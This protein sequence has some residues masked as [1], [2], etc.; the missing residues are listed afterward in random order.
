MADA[1]IPL[2]V[3]QVDPV[4]PLIMLQQGRAQQQEQQ[5]QR[6]R[7][8]N[9]DAM[10]IAD[11]NQQRE[12]RDLQMQGQKT[13]NTAANMELQRESLK[14][15]ARD[16]I[17]MDDLI[18][19]GDLQSAASVAQDIRKTMQQAG[20]PTEQF[21]RDILGRFSG[22]LDGLKA[23]SAQARKR[24]E[25]MLGQIFADV[26]NEQGQLVGQRNTET[27]QLSGVPDGM[28][29]GNSL[30][31]YIQQ[32]ELQEQQLQNQRLENQITQDAQAANI[33]QTEAATKATENEQRQNMLGN[34]QVRI[35]DITKRMLENEG[36]LSGAT[37]PV[38][39]RLPSFRQQTV[40]FEADFNE[41]GNLLTMQN[42]G[43]MT[44]VLSNSDLLIIRNAASGLAQG[45]S[46]DRM[47]TYLRQIN[48]VFSRNPAVAQ[49]IQS[50][51]NAQNGGGVVDRSQSEVTATNPQTGQRIALRNGQWVPL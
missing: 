9:M 29:Q 25:P 32:L 2:M 5:Y 4:S 35:Y 37:G 13:Q 19:A 11:L 42:L 20:I 15:I 33:R 50:Q 44:G 48:D 18:Q 24:M 21:E 47:K 14:L 39:S 6:Q 41:L 34:E 43:R 12:A 16:G 3:Q 49:H 31:A 27:G 36:G 10:T 51:Q 7:Q 30:D 26:K 17:A 40:D 1:R 46:E 23:A 8:Q 38:S 22:P 28:R 45:G